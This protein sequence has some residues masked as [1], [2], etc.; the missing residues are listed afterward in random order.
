MLQSMDLTLKI[1]QFLMEFHKVLLLP[2]FLLYI[3]DLHTAVKFCKVHHFADDNNL[4]YICKSI[5]QLN[6][7]VIFD[8]KNF[9]NWLNTN[10][11]SLNISKTE[12]IIFK[13][14]MTKV[15]LIS[16]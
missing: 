10:K 12:L 2:L 13:P 11:I 1:Y 7:F 15:D 14:R 9:P 8:L 3:N 5:E 16:N 6:K 4:L